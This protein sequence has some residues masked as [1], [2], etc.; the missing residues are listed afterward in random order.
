MEGKTVG[1]SEESEREGE[2]HRLD[3][4]KG[5][6]S[7]VQGRHLGVAWKKKYMYYLLLYLHASLVGASLGA[8]EEKSKVHKV[9]QR[10]RYTEAFRI[11][12]YI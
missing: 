1:G 3:S 6:Q 7:S 5:L 10:H 2:E 4:T 12:E 9:C 11:N 8:G